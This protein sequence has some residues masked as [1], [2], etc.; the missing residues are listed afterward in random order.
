VPRS[1]RR[2]SSATDLLGWQP[3]QIDGDGR[4]DLIHPVL[5]GGGIVVESLRARGDGYWDVVSDPGI[6]VKTYFANTGVETPG[7]IVVDIS[8][9]GLSD[10]I[11][12]QCCNQSSGGRIVRSLLRNTDGK[13]SERT[14]VNPG[15]FR[16]LCRLKVGDVNGDGL[17]DLVHV[18]TNG[19]TADLQVYASDGNGGFEYRAHTVTWS[20][21]SPEDANL[22]EDTSLVRFMDL[23]GDRRTDFVHVATYV[24]AAGQRRT[25]ILTASAP[26]H[27]PPTG[28]WPTQLTK[29]LAF[30]AYDLD[31]WRWQPW[32]EPI[33]GDTGLL[34]VH[35]TQ[36]QAYLFRASRNR[37]KRFS[38]GRGGITN[39]GCSI[40][41]GA[42]TY[43]PERS[44]PLVVTSL[45]TRDEAHSPAVTETV[46]YEYGD[47]RY[48]IELGELGF[49]WIQTTDSARAS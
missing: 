19:S 15:Y 7:L 18:T 48:S 49:G 12:A 8:G 11:H 26:S 36:S 5:S 9:D 38:N 32:T 17:S 1:P 25:A 41:W 3:G 34:Y 35:P 30:A 16:D 13:F 46:T 4:G 21:S 44:L 40:L 31:P 47:A 42:R 43:L 23:D 20:S 29:G 6:P 14:M 2:S 27:N 39:I 28:A 22:L 45:E 24:D 33:T 10:I 37:A